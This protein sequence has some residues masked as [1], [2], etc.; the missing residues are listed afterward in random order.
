MISVWKALTCTFAA[1]VFGIIFGFNLGASRADFV[2]AKKDDELNRI[3]HVLDAM[4][5]PDSEIIRFRPESERDYIPLRRTTG[6]FHGY[7]YDLACAAFFP[8]TQIIAINNDWDGGV[9][10]EPMDE[11]KPDQ[12]IAP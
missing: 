9:V 6:T 1:L 7:K 11:P 3:K 10:M 12:S 2:S 8:N 5:G 4:H